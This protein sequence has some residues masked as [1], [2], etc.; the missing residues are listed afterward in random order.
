MK[1][2]VFSGWPGEVE[3]ELQDWIS[4]VGTIHFVTQTAIPSEKQLPIP[5]TAIIAEPHITITIFYT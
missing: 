4:T 3:R 1:G 2:K 5:E